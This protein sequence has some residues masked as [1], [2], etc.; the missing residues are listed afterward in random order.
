MAVVV[1]D[2]EDQAVTLSEPHR[3]RDRWHVR[4]LVDLIRD[5]RTEDQGQH[6]DTDVWVRAQIDECKREPHHRQTD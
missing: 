1:L 4:P 5:G 6:E 3:S 2:A